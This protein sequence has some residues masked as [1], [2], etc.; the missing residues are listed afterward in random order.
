MYSSFLN[1]ANG[2]WVKIITFYC[3]S[4]DKL[5][6]LLASHVLHFF[7]LSSSKTMLTLCLA[8]P[9]QVKLSLRLAQPL[10]GYE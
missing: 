6:L 3:K 9:C 4:V 7:Q 1:L 2:P 8:V 10:S 5:K